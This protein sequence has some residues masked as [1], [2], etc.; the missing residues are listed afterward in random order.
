MISCQ[1]QQKNE[2][3]I[4]GNLNNYA[5]IIKGRKI[6]D[7]SKICTKNGFN[8][9]LEW[10]DSLQNI[11]LLNSISN[12]FSSKRIVFTQPNNLTY[13]LEIEPFKRKFSGES[14]G[15]ITLIIEK[16]KLKINSYKGGFVIN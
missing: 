15:E 11:A 10:S 6:D 8:S 7:I 16:G 3:D 4:V 12:T 13:R 2:F 1:Y 5:K 14:T 9:I